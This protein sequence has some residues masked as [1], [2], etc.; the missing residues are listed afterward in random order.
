MGV[1]RPGFGERSAKGRLAEASIVA[2]RDGLAL[3][4]LLPERRPCSRGATG[5][6]REQKGIRWPDLE[7]EI[8]PPA[9]RQS[10]RQKESSCGDGETEGELSGWLLWQK[11][12]RDM[13]GWCD[14]RAGFGPTCFGLVRVQV[15]IQ[16]G[17]GCS[18]R[19][20]RSL[21]VQGELL[22]TKPRLY[23]LG[24]IPARAGRTR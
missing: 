2:A 15:Y 8:W 20:R 10:K 1:F 14:R 19:P 16:R 6:L 7:S 18:R 22:L 13:D 21:R 4:D 11:L 5:N 12:P 23:F 17:R 3:R 9:G 24:A